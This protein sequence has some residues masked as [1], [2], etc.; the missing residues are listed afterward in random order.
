MDINSSINRSIDIYIYIYII[1]GL[2][3]KHIYIIYIY[4][5]VNV[6]TVNMWISTHLHFL[7]Y[8]IDVYIYIYVY[9]ACIY[10]CVHLT[11]DPINKHR[12]TWCLFLGCSHVK[13]CQGQRAQTHGA[14]GPGQP[15]VLVVMM[16]FLNFLY[17]I[18]TCKTKG[19]FWRIS[20]ANMFHCAEFSWKP[21]AILVP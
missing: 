4:I 21:T 7:K 15:F 10:V 16:K 11:L 5:H 8:N 18:V 20:A 3:R 19:K 17:M 2:L 14:A 12:K 13:P 6:L 1:L 9:I